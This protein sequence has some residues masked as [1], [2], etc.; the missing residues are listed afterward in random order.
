M[1]ICTCGH[2]HD[3]HGGDEEYPGSTACT[4]PGCDC[5]AYEEGDDETDQTE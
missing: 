5:I 1:N 3:E 2:A 4:V